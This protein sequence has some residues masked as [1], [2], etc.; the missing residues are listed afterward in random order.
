MTQDLQ[1]FF[2]HRG[3]HYFGDTI[4]LEIIVTGLLD[5]QDGDSLVFAIINKYNAIDILHQQTTI[6]KHTIPSNILSELDVN[7]YTIT[8]TLNNRQQIGYAQY[9]V[10]PVPVASFTSL[11]P[12]ILQI[13]INSPVSI[14]GQWSIEGE[15]MN[16]I[17]GSSE[18]IWSTASINQLN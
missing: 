10:V 6:H 13:P 7:D 3:G 11:T 4:P 18:L 14:T 8:V 5:V 15:Q 17:S 9:R 2:G 12:S 16:S 1:L